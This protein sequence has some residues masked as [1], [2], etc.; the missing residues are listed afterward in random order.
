MKPLKPPNRPAT[1]PRGERAG[2]WGAMTS[3]HATQTARS[4]LYCQ[5]LRLP[6]GFPLHVEADGRKWCWTG[7]VGTDIKTGQPSA[8]Y[9]T[10]AIRYWRRADGTVTAD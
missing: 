6:D 8:E 4:S 1:A 7:K 3:R 5:P 2:F 10:D 9:G